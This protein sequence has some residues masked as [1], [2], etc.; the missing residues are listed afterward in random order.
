[1]AVDRSL[2]R[3]SSVRGVTYSWA[4]SALAQR[5]SGRS[6]GLMAQE[7][8]KAMGEAV[9][10][11]SD[12]SHLQINYNEVVPVLLE[13]VKELRFLANE[14]DQ[15]LQ[16]SLASRTDVAR[17]VR[18][19]MLRRAVAAASAQVDRLAQEGE[20]LLAADNELEEVLRRLD[21]ESAHLPYTG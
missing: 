10:A 6:V 1:M 20:A 7:L 8:R 18:V 17:A 21:A 16:Q 12:G 11:S 14:S 2:D 19:E 15:L 5:R 3:V 13:S 9:V 4:D